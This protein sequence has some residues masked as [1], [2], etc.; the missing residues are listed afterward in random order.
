MFLKKKNKNKNKKKSEQKDKLNKKWDSERGYDKLPTKE[1]LS[2][3]FHFVSLYQ[4]KIT[5]L[6]EIDF[7]L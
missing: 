4:T 1:K 2:I 3:S 7:I 6:R 5:V